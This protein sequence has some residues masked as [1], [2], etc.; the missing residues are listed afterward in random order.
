MYSLWPDGRT[1]ATIAFGARSGIA[2]APNAEMSLSSSKS[3][4]YRAPCWI[5]Y[6]KA[7][8]LRPKWFHR[9]SLRVANG[10]ASCIATVR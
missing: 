1:S 3:K 2:S 7:R 8:F 5:A 4:T 10:S 6:R 9:S